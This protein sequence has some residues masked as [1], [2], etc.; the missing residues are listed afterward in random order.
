[1]LFDERRNGRGSP[2]RG[3]RRLLCVD[4]GVAAGDEAF[5]VGLGVGI[6]RLPRPSSKLTDYLSVYEC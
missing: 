1:M 3:C 5:I 4:E 6:A 2:R